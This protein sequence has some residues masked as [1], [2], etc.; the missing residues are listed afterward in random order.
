MR[1]TLLL[2]FSIGLLGHVFAQQDAQY[3]MYRF[4][5]LYIN[6]AYTAS[7][8]VL[9]TMAIYR[10]QWAKIPGQPQSA[11]VSAHSP[12]NNENVGLG[13]IY[14]FD[15]IGPT[16]TNSLNVS[17]AYRVAVGKKKKV[18]LSFGLSAGFSN[19]KSNLSNVTTAEQDDPSFAGANIN[20]W[21][22]NVGVG[23]YAYSDKF[24]IGASVPQLLAGRFSGKYSVFETSDKFSRQYHHLLFTAGYVFNLGSKA[25]FIPSG[26]LKIVPAHAPVSFDLNATFVIVDRVWLG[27]GYRYVD[28]YNFMAA[29]N[30]TKQLRIGYCYDLSVSPLSKYTT[31]SHEIMLS[32]DFRFEKGKIV[33]PRYLKYF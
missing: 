22:P 30:V 15:K 33:N 21:L 13:V 14:N 28:A 32:F 23:F 6:P 19:T 9:T 31:G 8:D 3:S 24:F 5:G 29:V 11:S 27:A 10:H 16:Q 7:H 25:K 4:N 1:N 2:L 17:F 18:K 20:R 12:L 26:L